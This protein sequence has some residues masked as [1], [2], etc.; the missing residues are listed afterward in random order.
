M[1]KLNINIGRLGYIYMCSMNSHEQP[2]LASQHWSI[3]LAMG[4]LPSSRDRGSEQRKEQAPSQLSTLRA[5]AETGWWLMTPDECGRID[6]WTSGPVLVA[7]PSS[8]EEAKSLVSVMEDNPAK[9]EESPAWFVPSTQ[10]RWQKHIQSWSDLSILSEKT[11]AYGFVLQ[12]VKM[13][14][15]VKSMIYIDIL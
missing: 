3:V 5:L 2:M 10:A 4:T 9:A 13:L 1:Y 14:I 7:S 6:Q 15:D 11:Y 12:K 8:E